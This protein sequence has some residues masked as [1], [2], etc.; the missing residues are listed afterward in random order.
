MAT[1]CTFSREICT[2]TQEGRE[3]ESEQ[4]RE[5]QEDSQSGS[6]KI[7]KKQVTVKLTFIWRAELRK[8]VR[9]LVFIV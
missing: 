7:P 9:D 5:A 8:S 1:I 3:G 2:D 4:G 6:G